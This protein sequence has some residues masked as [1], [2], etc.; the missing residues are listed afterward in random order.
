MWRTPLPRTSVQKKKDENMEAV[1]E[2]V[3]GKDKEAVN[4]KLLAHTDAFW[5]VFQPQKSRV[6]AIPDA[7]V[8][9]VWVT[10]TNQ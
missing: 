6:T 4:G 3:D 8:K 5:H 7:D 9:R 2:L 10:K 1:A